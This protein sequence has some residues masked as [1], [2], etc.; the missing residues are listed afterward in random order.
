MLPPFFYFN[1]SS[2][3]GIA[4]CTALRAIRRFRRQ[5]CSRCSNSNKYTS[6]W[7]FLN[8][9]S[10]F[11]EILRGRGL[12]HVTATC[13]HLCYI[14]WKGYL[15]PFW[16]SSKRYQISFCSLQ[17]GIRYRM[18]NPKNPRKYKSIACGSRIPSCSLQ[19]G[20]WL[21]LELL[22]KVIKYPSE[23]IACG[24]REL[25]ATLILIAIY[26]WEILI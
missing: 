15:P 14:A 3:S 19:K 26:R 5:Y 8:F 7:Y 1:L 25:H 11:R 9:S 24:I 13:K 18:Q 21:P 17:K 6:L 4:T 2:L 12:F 20:R 22:Q 23:Q 10:V 16:S